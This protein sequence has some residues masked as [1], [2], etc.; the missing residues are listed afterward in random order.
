[1]EVIFIIL[2]LG[3]SWLIWN[4]TDG[5][6]YREK[7]RKKQE[8]VQQKVARKVQQDSVAKA[9]RN[10]PI[11]AQLSINEQEHVMIIFKKNS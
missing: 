6:A 11:I 5:N 9:K 1:M 8:K 4:F 10:F 3:L 7:K 2:C